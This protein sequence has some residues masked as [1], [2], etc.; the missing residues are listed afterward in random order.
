[1]PRPSAETKSNLEAE[2][3]F[4]LKRL[5]YPKPEEEYYFHP[6]RKFRADRAYPHRKIL[7]EVEGGI[8]TQGRHTRPEGYTRDC[9]KYSWASIMGYMIIR[10]TAPMLR[11]TEKGKEC[12]AAQLMAAAWKN[13]N[14]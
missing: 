10:L 9:E 3:D 4:L 5:G 13:T 11:V 1:M 8:Y 7:I 14:P 2:L 6:D 12:L